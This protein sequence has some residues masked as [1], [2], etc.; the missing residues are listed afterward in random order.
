MNLLTKNPSGISGT[1][2]SDPDRKPAIDPQTYRDAM[3]RFAGAVSVITT[4]GP[5]GKRGAT[6]SAAVSVSD[7]PPTLAVCLLRDRADNTLFAENG[8]F[9]LNVLTA[10]QEK[11]ARV[12]AGEGDLEMEERFA[13]GDWTQLETGVPTLN[14][15]RTV[16]DCVVVDVQ[17]VHTHHVIFGEVVAAGPA[18]EGDALVYLDPLA[19]SP[20][21]HG[22]GDDRHDRPKGPHDRTERFR[23]PG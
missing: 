2:Q 10:D 4:D 19:R 15:A 13:L 1:A 6:V 16:L 3:S 11:L 21:D 7:N 9:A 14:G 12:F 20:A 17:Q 18:N 23:A 22:T 8:R 5:A